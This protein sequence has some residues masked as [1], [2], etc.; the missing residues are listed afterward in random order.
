MKRLS[1]I[2]AA[3][4]LAGVFLCAGCGKSGRT[5]HIYTWS[6]Y[7]SPDVIASF[8][9]TFGAE[10]V[11]DTFD[12]NESM[13]AKLK[14][15]GSGYDLILPSTYLIGTM[16]RE[17]MIELID[18]TKCPNVKKN[19][20]ASYAKLVFDP[21][22]KYSVPYSF[23][24]TGFLY[25]KRKVPAGADVASWAILGNPALRGRVTLLDDIRDVIGAGLMYH[26]HSI[27]ST[28]PKE[29]NEAVEQV[30][31]WRANVRKFDCESYK[32]E[33]PGGATWLAQGF[34]VD[35][36]QIAVGDE[37][38]GVPPR[39]DIG[40]ALPKEGFSVSFDEM[41]VARG[42]R[43]KDLAYAFINYIYDEEIA[44][45]NMRYVCGLNPVRPG[46]A[47]LDEGFRK[48][49]VLTPEQLAHGQVIRSFDDQ[50]DVQELYNKAWDRIK[51]SNSK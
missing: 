24:C 10:V 7:I 45:E 11:I 42:S 47:R 34:S 15:G 17:G 51:S 8:E 39:D 13:Y 23:S 48:R 26:G 43:Q 5:L 46:I 1:S 19:F 41:V 30:L 14:A 33:V 25:D 35:A 12:S 40:F 37:E 9:K 28:D 4:V 6:D 27:N 18:H 44:A 31:A 3:V 49:L 36:V 20:D 38:S 2:F 16:V 32:T 50:P 29:I 21:S 22:L